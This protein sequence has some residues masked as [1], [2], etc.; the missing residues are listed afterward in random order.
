MH[1]ASVSDAN[2]RDF[3]TARP[4][5]VMSSRAAPLPSLPTQPQLTFADRA[6]ARRASRA[7]PGAGGSGPTRSPM[8]RS[9]C[10][11]PAARPAPRRRCRP[12][13]TACSPP[14]MR[15]TAPPLRV[16]ISSGVGVPCGRQHQL[17]SRRSWPVSRRATSAYGVS[18]LTDSRISQI[19]GCGA[20]RCPAPSGARLLLV[21]SSFT[22]HE[23]DNYRRDGFLAVPDFLTEAEL[24]HWRAVVDAAAADE[25]AQAGTLKQ[26]VFTQRMQLRRTSPRRQAARG[27]SADRPARGGAR[28]PRRAAHLP[29]PGARQGAVRDADAIS[30]GPAVVLVRLAS[31][32]HDLG[33]AGR[34]NAGERLPVLRARQPRA[35]PDR[36][37]RPRSRP[38]GR[39]PRP[40]R[41]GVDAGAVPAAGRRLL[42]PQRPH[43]PRRRREH[44][45][46]ATARDVGRPFMPDGGSR[47]ELHRRSREPVPTSARR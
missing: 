25:R 46:R 43:G 34:R 26:H 38:R 27:G 13:T 30:P 17:P 22:P 1:Q 36:A 10:R 3:A 2:P 4:P 47:P 40:S 24:A 8:T 39:V 12:D 21:R 11:S 23:I 18:D 32:V 28:G 16:W 19:F 20:H 15:R 14:P 6:T 31:R 45:A 9:G 33:R 37:G 44:D 35:R 42:I 7:T 41:G 29:R 5:R